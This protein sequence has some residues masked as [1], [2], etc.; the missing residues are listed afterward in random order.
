MKWI[1]KYAS[2]LLKRYFVPNLDT[3][4]YILIPACLSLV[5][6][7]WSNP[8]YSSLLTIISGFGTLT[9]LKSFAY[10]TKTFDTQN[11]LFNILAKDSLVTAI[12][13]ATYFTTNVI[14]LINDDLLKGKLGCVIHFAGMFLPVMLGPLS[15]FLISLRRFIQLKFP[16]A[17]APKSLRCNRIVN[18]ILTISAIYHIVI[19]LFDTFKDI[20]TFKFI[21]H[22]QRIPVLED[23]SKVIW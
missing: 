9:N 20:K 1:F 7:M 16:N 5:S 19:L 3:W 2:L 12:C 8:V 15:S 13:S 6:R 11:N 18:V 10:V 21:A 22:C 4:K 14:K 17:I 23:R